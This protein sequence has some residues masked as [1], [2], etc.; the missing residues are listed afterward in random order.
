MF[1][2]SFHR[3]LKHVYLKGKINKRMDVFI[4]V[5]L[6][7]SRD[8]AFDRILKVEK[9]KTTKRCS[10]IIKRH[11]RSLKIPVE[12]VQAL[13]KNSKW[14]VKSNTTPTTYSVEKKISCGN[15]YCIRCRPCGI[16]IHEYICTCPDS[17]LRGTI[18]KHIHLVI[19]SMTKAPP[20]PSQTSSS[21]KAA[22]GVTAPGQKL[23]LSVQNQSRKGGSK[24]IKERLF[25]KLSNISANI[26]D[27]Q[28]DDILV[29]IEKHLN[30]C[31]SIM[32]VYRAEPANK[33][34][35][36]QRNFY[37]TKRKREAAK[38]KLAKPSYQQKVDI[39]NR[40]LSNADEEFP[41]SCIG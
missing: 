23:L 3:V 10:D 20:H 16:C 37:S 28:N 38:I 34:I 24:Q 18:C 6:R 19:R 5:L 2:E 12:L 30:A 8:K 4:N 26:K 31:I 1:A 14:L 41:R 21:G 22:E 36:Q 9:G 11:N 25:L 27:A 29:A 17:L 13:D 15:N 40:L 33:G 7:Y 32:N 39:T 35:Q